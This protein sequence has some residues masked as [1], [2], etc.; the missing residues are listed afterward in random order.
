MIRDLLFAAAGSASTSGAP[1][2]WTFLLSSVYGG[3]TGHTGTQTKTSGGLS[4][5]VFSGTASVA[6]TV[7]GE[8]GFIRADFGAVKIVSQIRIA[9][10]PASF[11]GWG[12][13]YLNGARLEHS[14][15]GANW[16]FIQNIAGA[17]DNQILTINTNIVARYVRV[18]RAEHGYIGVSELVFE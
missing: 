7:S 5:G 17:V 6:A 18:A 12:A 14:V 10:I 13:Y 2:S 8:W 1:E 16:S 3:Y 11:E 15:D 9:P 4:D